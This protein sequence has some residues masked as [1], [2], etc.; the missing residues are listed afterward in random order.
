[1]NRGYDNVEVDM[2]GLITE[3]TSLM[4][5]EFEDEVWDVQFEQCK[6]GC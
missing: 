2:Y 1:M 5:F 4:K 3:W 6:Y